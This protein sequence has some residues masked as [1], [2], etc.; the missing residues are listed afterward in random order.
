[1]SG[2]NPY[3]D[4]I[5]VIKSCHSEVY[6]FLASL[7]ILECITTQL[8]RSMITNHMRQNK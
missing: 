2:L 1:M 8:Q 5:I 6:A 4:R 7:T 3:F